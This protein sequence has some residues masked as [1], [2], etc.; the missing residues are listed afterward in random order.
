MNQS[1]T[2]ER[3][4]ARLSLSLIM[5]LLLC[6]A[7]FAQ[8]APL[9]KRTTYK[10]E[11]IDFGA[12]GTLSIVGAPAGAIIVEGWRKNE[13]EITAEVEVQAAN[14]KDL[15]LLATVDT[16]KIDNDFGHVRVV[17]VGTYNKD[18][19]KPIAKKFPKNLY[20]APFRIDYRIKVPLYC[21]LEIDGG[22]GD[23][24]LS[25]VEGAI[26]IKLLESN[27]KL[28]LVGGILSATVG[29][30]SVDVMVPSRSWRGRSVDVQLARGNIN[31][32]FAPY[33]NAEV[34][35][36]ILREGRIENSYALLKPSE[37]TKFTEK[38]VVAKSGGGGAALSF[39]VGDGL[40]KLAP[41]EK[42]N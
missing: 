11:R 18:Y 2:P 10:T 16:F 41:L 7:C 13:I 28:N 32:F 15:A 39:T 36:T 34:S 22:R 35:A 8:T 14:E 4:G 38:S 33:L 24:T 6:A 19:M 3:I 30:G 17:S 40:I 9:L 12:G 31:A 20:N 5:T 1:S 27:V 29:S 42:Q 25:G 23:L 26:V 21:D 37:R